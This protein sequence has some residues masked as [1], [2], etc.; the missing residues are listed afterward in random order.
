MEVK[1]KSLDDVIKSLDD[2]VKSQKEE[3]FHLKGQ[4]GNNNYTKHLSSNLAP[5]SSVVPNDRP[6][7]FSSANNTYQSVYYHD[8]SNDSACKSLNARL[9]EMKTVE[10]MDNFHRIH[11][12]V[13]SSGYGKTRAILE[14]QHQHLQP[15]IYLSCM[16]SDPLANSI[17]TSMIEFMMSPPS[18]DSEKGKTPAYIR[19]KIA[20][21]IV[22]A[23]Q[24]CA[25][26][27]VNIESLIKS[28][29]SGGD[30]FQNLKT[31]WTKVTSD[32]GTPEYVRKLVRFQDR[33]NE[34]NKRIENNENAEN[35]ECNE[36][37]SS[38]SEESVV[39]ESDNSIWKDKLVIAF[40]EID[41]IDSNNDV[42]SS[43][44]IRCLQRAINSSHSFGIFLSTC[45][46][47]NKVMPGHG[48]S[49]PISIK[50]DI[51]PFYRI[52]FTDL[53]DYNIFVLGLFVFFYTETFLFI[54][55]LYLIVGRP[56]WHSMYKFSDTDIA[57]DYTKL[58]FYAKKLLLSQTTNYSSKTENYYD[59]MA[60][61][62]S[63]FSMK[64]IIADSNTFLT[65]H[66]A[67]LI[68]FSP[69]RSS[70][71]ITYP[72]EPLLSEVSVGLLYKF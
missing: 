17:F 64:F 8:E 33:D 2:V 54:K 46:N 7:M 34:S 53:Y 69:D 3:I 20:N 39:I 29:D 44:C 71:Y 9:N 15:L 16:P 68:G 58:M 23:I 36:K 21:K 60:I 57:N 30:F 25:D 28:Q 37:S 1:E 31:E 43:S 32:K 6:I 61:F 48:G 45:S 51:E 5:T 11:F 55:F 49:R 70:Y 65:N 12:L 56:L 19:N 13:Q 59:L 41:V 18:I 22:C 50:Q 35:N 10:S 24:K 40:D 14:L 66:L 42:S 47:I 26:K 62:C 4:L 27:Y 63:R 72:S 38:L 52:V 67:T